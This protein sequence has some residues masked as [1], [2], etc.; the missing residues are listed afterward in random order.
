MTTERGEGVPARPFFN[1]GI[2]A[3]EQLVARSHRDEKVL[4]SVQEELGH[5]SNS[6]ALALKQ[7]IAELLVTLAFAQ[8]SGDT[9]ASTATQARTNTSSAPRTNG[10]ASTRPNV[11]RGEPPASAPTASPTSNVNPPQPSESANA[12]PAEDAPLHQQLERMR[13]R[14]LDL[15]AKNRLL[16]FRHA[17]TSCVRVIDETPTHIFDRITAGQM[18]EFAP[19]RA[20]EGDELD[21]EVELSL[22]AEPDRSESARKRERQE[23]KLRSRA[24]TLGLDPSYEL[25]GVEQPEH[26]RHR[27]TALQTLVLPDELESVLRKIHQKGRT[28]IQET[29]ANVLHLLFG[30]VEWC[31]LPPEQATKSDY[32]LAPL[33]LVPVGIERGRLDTGTRPRTYLYTVK[34]T[35]EDWDT[36]VTLQE[37]CRREQGTELPGI[38]EEEALEVYFRRIEGW[39][40]EHTNGWRLRRCVTLG[41]V[42]FGKILMWRDLDPKTWPFQKSLLS[43]ALM[44]EVLGEDADQ[45]EAPQPLTDEYRLDEPPHDVTAPPV[46]VDADSSQHSVLVDVARWKNLVVQGPPGTGKSQT[47]ANLI[48]AEIHRGRRVLFVAEKKAALDVVHRRLTGIG[49]GPYCLALHSHTSEKKAF[50][51]DLADRIRVR[52]TVRHPRDLH[53]VQEQLEEHRRKLNEYVRK[54]HQPHAT[55]ELTGFEILWRARRLVDPMTPEARRVISEARVALAHQ[56]TRKQLNDY[57]SVLSEFGANASDVLGECGALRAHPWFGVTNPELTQAEIEQLLEAGRRWAAAMASLESRFEAVDRFAGVALPHSVAGIEKLHS[58]VARLEVPPE[59]ARSQMPMRVLQS[60]REP[61]LA[62][63][64]AAVTESRATWAKIDG[65]WGRPG[66]LAR[67]AADRFVGA[68]AAAERSLGEQL[69]FGT[70]RGL[71]GRVREL[72]G[73]LD[74]AERL[75]SAAQRVL[76]LGLGLTPRVCE[77]LLKVVQLSGSVEAASLEL[78]NDALKAEGVELGL[79]ALSVAAAKLVERREELS[80]SWP[81]SLR[82]DAPALRDHIAAMANAPRFLPGLFSKRY[83]QAVAAFRTATSR[84]APRIAMLAEFRAVLEFEDEAARFAASPE[85]ARLFGAF[86]RGLDSPFDGALRLVQWRQQVAELARGTGGEGSKLQAAAWDVGAAQWREAA[87]VCAQGPGASDST[88]K[89]IAGLAALASD[90]EREGRGWPDAS[91]QQVR[92]ELLAIATVLASAIEVFSSAGAAEDLTLR[93]LRTRSESVRA[94]WARDDAAKP[95]IAELAQVETDPGDITACAELSAALSYVASLRACE[96]PDGALPS[97]L[98]GNQAEALQAVRDRLASAAEEGRSMCAAAAPFENVGKLDHEAWLGTGTTRV[99]DAAVEQLRDRL[100][101]ALEAD[102]A[103]Y[104]WARYV[105]ARARAASVGGEDICRLVDARRLPPSSAADGFE[106]A[107][108]GTVANAILRSDPDL[109]RFSGTAHEQVRA[110]F[111]ELDEKSLELTAELIAHGLAGAPEIRGVGY[112]AVRDQTEE[113]LIKQQAGLQRPRVTIRDLFRRAGR[114]IVNLKPCVMMSPQA[115]SQYLPPGVLD[116]DLVVMDEASQIRPED[117]LGAIARAKQMVV[118]GDPM[119]LG[120]TSFFDR[121][122]DD[123]DDDQTEGEDASDTAVAPPPEIGPTVLERSESILTAAQARYPLR[124]LRWHYRSRHPKLIAFSNREFYGE[125]LVVFPTPQFA[126]ARE[127]VFFR[128]IENS[129]Y[130]GHRNLKEAEAIVEAVRQHASSHLDQTLLVATLNY[131]QADLIDDLLQKAEKLDPVIA[132]YRK[133]HADG[134]EPLDIKNLENVQGDER[135][136]ILVSITFGPKPDGQFSRNFGPINQTGGERRLNVLF[137]RAKHRLEV[138]CS[139]D[140]RQLGVGDGSPRGLRVLH[141]YLR[142]AED[143]TWATGAPDGREPDSDFEIAVARALRAEGFEVHPQVGIAGY[144]IDLGIVHPQCP[145]TYVLG[146]E[147]DGATYHCARSARDRDRLRQ[148]V[149]EGYGWKI[150]R[151]W[152]TDWFRDPAKQVESV[153]AKI[154]RSVELASA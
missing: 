99:E 66:T 107:A 122:M 41:L 145:G 126:G 40:D 140:P 130:E 82:P 102:K 74:S 49:L 55:L 147:C 62:T 17:P 148:R 16:N 56:M 29:G 149:L 67:D 58:G 37:K 81:T 2:D 45:A 9:Q 35:G 33:V 142:Y 27:D 111:A 26:R 30:F 31:D 52:G 54:L 79:T 22:A 92:D 116:F 97:M 5:R 109:L 34:A 136:V 83:R 3:L 106:A 118:V 76:G 117:A 69:T 138:F 14:L 101:M 44:R 96:L 47:I 86:A 132:E 7:R 77:R 89:L 144:W 18:M 28:A 72:V 143:G 133:R 123:N 94:A 120:P 98:R 51:Q 95:L 23:A 46:V 112:G 61:E 129:V 135:D 71:A 13:R 87:A 91:L 43:N 12:V 78:R 139:F 137:T 153:V 80:K 64:L 19:L 70:A 88:L 63:A 75:A 10:A 150:H 15:T 65:A 25:P 131:H 134:P 121:H 68:I 1:H 151:I 104:T 125:D 119:Q 53:A 113:S 4:R 50:L 84:R 36:N 39:L 103:V 110:R 93:G 152:S 59:V 21:D 146:V 57:K 48:A 105:H 124:M 141:D 85:L 127:G 32:R 100:R 90:I 11:A 24:K 20:D 115:I 73:A 38:E 60:H 6:R 128:K 42:S 8:T 114:A 108:Y 154:R